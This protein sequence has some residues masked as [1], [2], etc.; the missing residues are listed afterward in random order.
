MRKRHICMKQ[1]SHICMGGKAHGCVEQG[2]TREVRSDT[3]AQE[4]SP[5]ITAREA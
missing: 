3:D 4:S 5:T 2:C 1:E